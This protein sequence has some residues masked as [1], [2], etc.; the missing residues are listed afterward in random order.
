MGYKI[1]GGL[2]SPTH[3][4]YKKKDLAPSLHRCAMIEQA[5]VALPW[6]KI[7]DW[8]VKQ[9]G[10]TRTKQVLQYHQVNIYSLVPTGEF[11][12]MSYVNIAE[13]SECDSCF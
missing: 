6:V 2:I 12:F 11:L 13:S 8:E 1:Y 10:W 4:A 7:S 9:D 5:L 3:D